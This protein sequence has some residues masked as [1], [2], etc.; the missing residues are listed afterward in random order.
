MR[1]L[2]A[3]VLLKRP[4]ISEQ[5]GH[6][7]IPD[8]YRAIPQEGVI[9]AVSAGEQ[10]VCSACG[11]LERRTPTVQVGQTVLHG[12]YSRMGLPEEYGEALYLVFERDLMA[13]IE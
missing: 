10:H 8:K 6:I 9:V 4:P 2:G 11:H 12:R 3:R 5:I 7:I 13:V 1:P